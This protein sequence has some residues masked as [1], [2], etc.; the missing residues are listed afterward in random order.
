MIEPLKYF[1][2]PEVKDLLLKFYSKNLETAGAG[3]ELGEEIVNTTWENKAVE[4]EELEDLRI[5][6]SKIFNTAKKKAI[7]IPKERFP[8]E[9]IDY[10]GVSSFLDIGANKLKYVNYLAVKHPEIKELYALD[11]V[12]INGEFI[13]PDKSR[14]IQ[15]SGN[16]TKDN[17]PIKQNSIDLVNVQFVFH[18]MNSEEEILNEL[19]IINHI[20]RPGGRFILWE[21]SFINLNISGLNIEEVVNKACNLGIS[22]DLEMTKDYYS[23]S[24][25][26]KFEFIIVNDWITQVSNP[27]MQWTG[28]YKTWERWKMLLE[29]EGFKLRNEYILGLRNSG[30]LKQG[31]HIIGEFY[32]I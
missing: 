18:H 10:S 21:E 2:S 1:K 24:D 5:K 19:E 22:S 9:L 16:E 15:V 20:L 30:A 32:R 3:K 27:H 6:I 17:F 4:G 23:L 7:N 11:V 12:P 25:D 8:Y 13:A 28:Q 29:S 31:V 14:Y 26:Q